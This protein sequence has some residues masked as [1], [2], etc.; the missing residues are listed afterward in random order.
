MRKDT[1]EEKDINSKLET[2]EWDDIWVIHANDEKRDRVM[3][4]GDSISRGY[5]H[6]AAE[7]LSGDFYVD[8]YATSKGIDNPA[9]TKTIS[10][11][12]AQQPKYKVIHFNNGLHGFHLSDA[13][14]EEHFESVIKFLTETYPDKK[15]IIGLTTP[16]RERGN[17]QNLAERNHRVIARNRAAVRI[18]EKYG[19][20]VNDLYS[21]LDGTNK[22]HCEDG[23]HLIEE[24]Y[25]LLAE[26]I[27]EK[28]YEVLK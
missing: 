6:K 20:A 7:A 12:L 17:T 27:K 28:V 15:L 9:L 1:Y 5:R 26:K 25:E 8:N 11:V 18:A 22:Y 3:L 16:A 13:E 23:I 21:V 19:I 4:I 2:Y 14:Y 24:G 10:L